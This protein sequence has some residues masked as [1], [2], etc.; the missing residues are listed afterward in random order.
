MQGVGPLQLTWWEYQ[1]RADLYGGCWKPKCNYRVGF[2]LLA[3]LVKH[4][5]ERKGLAIYNGGL[6]HPNYEYASSVLDK[7]DKWHRLLT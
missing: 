4:H 3:S 2:R 1:N 7:K 5:G 6:A